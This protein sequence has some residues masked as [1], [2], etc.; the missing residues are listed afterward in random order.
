MCLQKQLKEGEVM[1]LTENKEGCMGG[2][3]GRTGKREVMNYTV[4][5]KSKEIK[6]KKKPVK[7]LDIS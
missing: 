6:I 4:I 1:N 2:F 5:S 3:G 7:E